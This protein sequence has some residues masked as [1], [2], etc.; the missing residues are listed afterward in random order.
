MQPVSFLNI[1]S[2]IIFSS[3]RLIINIPF[4]SCHYRTFNLM[5]INMVYYIILKNILSSIKWL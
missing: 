3:I 4:W 1:R 5:F 2:G